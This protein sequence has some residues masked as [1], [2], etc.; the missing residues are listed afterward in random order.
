MD[1][2]LRQNDGIR[3]TTGMVFPGS[4]PTLDPGLRQDDDSKIS[5]GV[6]LPGSEPTLDPGLRQDDGI[7]VAIGVRLEP[8][9]Q[10][11]FNGTVEEYPHAVSFRPDN[12]SRGLQ[13]GGT[14]FFLELRGKREAKFQIKLLTDG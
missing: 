9:L 10:T 5:I 6:V 3:V 2:G 12:P 7:R 1:S 14:V 11:D 8:Y 13:A 4:E